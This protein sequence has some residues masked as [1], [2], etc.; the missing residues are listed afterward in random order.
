MQ[1][2]IKAIILFMNCSYFFLLI[3]FLSPQKLGNESPYLNGILVSSF[4]FIANIFMFFTLHRFDRKFFLNL[5]IFGYVVM[6]SLLI[7]IP[8]L[9]GAESAFSVHSTTFIS[10]KFA[11]LLW[12]YFISILYLI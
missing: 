11:F 1:I 7:L 8:A 2:L 5:T 12:C 10:C 6:S 3:I 9:S 4:A